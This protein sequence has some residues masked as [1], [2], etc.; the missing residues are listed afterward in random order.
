MDFFCFKIND[1]NH[2]T[3]DSCLPVLFFLFTTFTSSSDLDR[4]CHYVV[5]YIWMEHQES[6]LLDICN[7]AE[8]EA[9]EKFT[10]KESDELEELKGSRWCWYTHDVFCRK[11]PIAP[12]TPK[13]IL[14][15]SGENNWQRDLLHKSQILEEISSIVSCSFS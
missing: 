5:S 7:L 9:Q 12:F 14:D 11:L 1:T 4:S 8:S 3:G 13:N 15:P 2:Q 6:K 10:R